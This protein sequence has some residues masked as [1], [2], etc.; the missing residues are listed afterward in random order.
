M[1][2]RHTFAASL[3][4]AATTLAQTPLDAARGYTD[5]S[6]VK[7]TELWH[8][9][10]GATFPAKGW[11]VEKH[12]IR[13]T[14]PG[15]GDLVTN[16]TF[17]DFE[18]VGAFKLEAK[19]NSGI[20]WRVAETLDATWQTGP[21]Y[22][23][24]ED[25]TYPG[26]ENLKPAQLSGALYDLLPPAEGKVLHPAGAWNDVR[27]Y[28]RHGLLQH[29]LNGKKVV[30]A[31]I[32]TQDGAFTK[33]W[34]E[35]I[36][37]SKFRDYRGFGVTPRGMIALQDHGGGVAFKDVK[38]RD[39]EATRP[40]EVALFNGSTLE[41]WHAVV[42]GAEKAGIKPLDV[43]SVADGVLTCK[44]TPGGYIRTEKKYTNYV[45][46]LQWRFM[47]GKAG[48]S[49]VLLRMVGED[50]VWPKS[51]E[52]QLQSGQAGDFW[53]IDEFKMTVEKSRTTGRNT[54]RTHTAERPLGEWNEY[55][56][57]VNKGDVVLHV[58]GEELNRATDVEEVAGYICLQSEGAEIQF[59]NIRLTPL[60]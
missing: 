39:L 27:I 20:M 35:K 51:V 32:Q 10:K 30:E 7:A 8:A 38:I 41:G 50:K 37:G 49:G 57:I 1:H 16:A 55:E 56:I 44:G 53:N 11:L 31:T 4:F 19:A 54:K 17:G 5:Y 12:E 40:N 34:L 29:W 21:E 9:Y 15:G 26:K 14:G 33:E 60:D 48:N 47:P 25:S 24:L 59:K 28:L 3:A 6:G 43:W 2:V 45:L 42:P 36:A 23:I 22:Q 18:F 52:A 46:R 58:N 13:Q